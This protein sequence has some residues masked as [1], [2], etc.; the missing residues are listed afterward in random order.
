MK[1]T[2]MSFDY[3]LTDLKI[4]RDHLLTKNYLPTKFKASGAKRYWVISCTRL[5][6]TDIPPDRHVQSDM[7]SFFKGGGHKIHIFLYPRILLWK[8]P[9]HM[10]VIFSV[11]SWNHQPIIF[12]FP[13]STKF[14][15]IFLRFRFYLDRSIHKKI[16]KVGILKYVKMWVSIKAG[17]LW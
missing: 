5:R 15:V 13:V 8:S 7:P 6:D 9:Y 3:G 16:P 11:G 10:Y 14:I 4:N 17:P 12:M 1:Q 2:G